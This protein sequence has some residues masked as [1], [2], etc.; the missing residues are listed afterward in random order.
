MSDG[1][2]DVNDARLILEICLQARLE[3]ERSERAA[4]EMLDSTLR[5]LREEGGVA[6][7]AR[8]REAQELRERVRDAQR[9]VSHT[10]RMSVCLSV[11]CFCCQDTK[12]C[13]QQGGGCLT[14]LTLLLDRDMHIYHAHA[15]ICVRAGAGRGRGGA[16]AR[17]GVAA[18]G[19]AAQR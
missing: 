8:E 17:R 2:P 14:S 13:K 5:Q 12:W 6:L 15:R 9:Q 1:W 18:E 11:F 7:Q 16:T 10:E 3:A 4:K 19:C